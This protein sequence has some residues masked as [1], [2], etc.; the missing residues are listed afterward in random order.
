MAAQPLERTFYRIFPLV[1][2]AYKTFFLLTI[3]VTATRLPTAL[4]VALA[5]AL[6]LRCPTTDVIRQ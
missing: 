5:I 4:T 1:V 6:S 2:S 3:V